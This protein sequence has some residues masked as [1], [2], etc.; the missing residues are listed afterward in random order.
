VSIELQQLSVQFGAINALRAVSASI[1]PGRV[2]VIIGP[3]AAGKSTLL[4]CMLGAQDPTTGAVL[5]DGRPVHR[6]RPR[7]VAARIAY[8]AQRSAVSAAFTAHE[9][10][11]LGRYALPPDEQRVRQAMQR[12]D[13]A[14]LADRIVPTLSAGQQQRVAVARALAQLE[15]DGVLLLDEPTSA[16]DLKHALRCIEFARSLADDGGT[17]ILSLHDLALAAAAADDILMLDE[18]RLVE[19]GPKDAVMTPDVLQRVFGVTFEWVQ[20]RDGGSILLPVTAATVTGE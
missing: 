13:I 19:H 16:M 6:M 12:M 2:T 18:G 5:L 17:V 10:V 7:H 20:R 9:V 15:P 1:Q 14:E 3:N 11:A 8:V 4:R